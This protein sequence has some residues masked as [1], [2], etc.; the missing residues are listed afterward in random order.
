MK[1]IFPTILLLFLLISIFTIPTISE[2]NV[3][4]TNLEIEKTNDKKIILFLLNK[5]NY[6]VEIP[7]SL[8]EISIESIINYLKE[9]NY[10]NKGKYFGYIP[11]DTKVLNYQIEDD[12]LTINFSEEFKN[13]NKKTIPGLV[14]SL[15]NIN[16]FHKVKILVD[17]NYIEG[18]E[19]ELDSNIAINQNYEFNNR[20]DI[21]KI[22]VYY[23]DEDYYVP[24]TKY[25]TT[26]NNKI[27]VLIEE[28]KQNVPDN[29]MSLIT[30]KINLLN[31]EEESD[32]VILEFNDELIKDE[33]NKDK[34]MKEIANSI[35]ENEDLSSVIFKVEK[36]IEKIISKNDK[37]REK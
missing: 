16:K 13:I 21:E 29:L 18:Y 33:K 11:K 35:L 6:L 5:N 24:V 7:V 12:I 20:T 3:L 15:L 25:V 9:D 4:R 1:K 26:N 2:K 14:K 28:L 22:I 34:I 10:E 36:K 8:K 37:I 19:K 32:T 23:L 30:S 17:N 27:E 31:I